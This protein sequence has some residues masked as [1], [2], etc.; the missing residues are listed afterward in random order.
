MHNSSLNKEVDKPSVVILAGGIS[1]RMGFPKAHLAFNEK[2]SFLKHLVE[3]YYRFGCKQIVVVINQ[4][5]VDERVEKIRKSKKAIFI[6]N[7]H[8]E[9]GRLYSIRLGSSCLQNPEHIFIQNI[10]SP[11]VS[12]ETL[13]KLVAAKT[14]NGFVSPVYQKKGGH[15]ILVSKEVLQM[16]TNADENSTLRDVLRNVARTNV[17]VE[18]EMVLYNCNT[19]KDY[20]DM[21]GATP[22]EKSL[23]CETVF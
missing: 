10:D 18:D 8:P 7:G 1:S 20:M 23:N 22:N 2:E 12:H 17:E 16:I 21:F 13:K 9:F 19:T 15:P 5:I 4:H 14:E 11:F 3:T 6:N